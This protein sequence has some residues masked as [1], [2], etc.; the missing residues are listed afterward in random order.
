TLRGLHQLRS[1]FAANKGWDDMGLGK[2]TQR[3]IYGAISEEMKS[4]AEKNGGVR[5]RNMMTSRIDDSKGMY[6]VIKQARI[7]LKEAAGNRVNNTP[8]VQAALGKSS[9]RRVAMKRILAEE[10]APAVRD[11]ISN[12]ILNAYQQ[13]PQAGAAM[14]RKLG[15][16]ITEFFGKDEAALYRGLEKFIGNMPK[17]GLDQLTSGGLSAAAATAGTVGIGA[18]PTA[19]IMGLT[20][21]ALRRK[22]I[23]AMLQKLSTAPKDSKL[24][25]ELSK[26][27][28]LALA[29]EGAR[30]EP[31]QIDIRNGIPQ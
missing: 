6:D 25:Q 7:P 31:M 2:K 5:A 11:Q 1:N 3:K 27:L 24:A 10:G 29:G 22:D 12:D 14:I 21:A 19:A 20:S 30:Q 18:I 28:G 13:S 26:Y 23:R 15:G 9:D 4:V 17:K 16:S 8:F